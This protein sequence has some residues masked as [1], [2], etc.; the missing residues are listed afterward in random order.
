MSFN[1]SAAVPVGAAWLTA[2]LH[3][4]TNTGQP[5]QRGLDRHLHVGILG[6]L[7]ECTRAADGQQGLVLLGQF[8]PVFANI[9]LVQIVGLPANREMH[10]GGRQRLVGGVYRKLRHLTV[11]RERQFL[12]ALLR[13]Q[14]QRQ[15]RGAE[16]RFP[17]RRPA[18][19]RG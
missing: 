3:G 12:A 13:R 14:V 7:I 6:G 4:A 1:L 9:D 18:S 8:E 19:R 15:V 16:E 11:E 10:I 17:R 2:V 5:V